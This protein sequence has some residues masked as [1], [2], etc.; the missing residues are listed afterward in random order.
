MH[1]HEYTDKYLISKTVKCYSK[2]IQY[3]FANSYL[4]QE[5]CIYTEVTNFISELYNTD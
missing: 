1:S 3:L 4:L 2:Y 5:V